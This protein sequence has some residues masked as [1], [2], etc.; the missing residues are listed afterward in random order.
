M[1][2][3]RSAF[4][5]SRPAADRRQAHRQVGPVLRDRDVMWRL[6][7]RRDH[8]PQDAG[9][10]GE[11]STRQSPYLGL[12]HSR[13][14]PSSTWNAARSAVHRLR[15]PHHLRGI[16]DPHLLTRVHEARPGKAEVL[17]LPELVRC[18]DVVARHSGQLLAAVRR[19]GRRR[20][21]VVPADR[22][23]DVQAD[24]RHS[25]QE[26]LRRQPRW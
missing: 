22:F 1:A 19:L 14:V 23:L 12:G 3:P 6:C 9:T 16:T 4:A 21:G 18:G 7:R 8:V 13:Q 17:R 26:G 2:S 11:R 15:A 10:S 24:R 25:S 5:W 20:S